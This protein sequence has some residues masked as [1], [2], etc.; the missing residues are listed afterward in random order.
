MFQSLD[1]R[2]KWVVVLF[3]LDILLSFVALASGAMEYQLLSAFASGDLSGYDNPIAAA[4]ASDARQQMIGIVQIGLYVSCIIAFLVWK[5]RAAANLRASGRG[6]LKFTPGWAVGWYFVPIASLVKP[7]QAMREIWQVS[8]NGP[9][10]NTPAVL[11]T[12]WTFWLLG[13]LSGQIAFRLSR[14]AETPDAMLRVSTASLASDALLIV[15]GALIIVIV[16][17]ISWAQSQ[18]QFRSGVQVTAPDAQWPPIAPAG[19]VSQK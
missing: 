17:R 12:W 1:T 19:V 4:E 6:P 14:S 11:G 16:R 5:H 10:A 7:L 9:V 13:N 18:P 3:S 2:C 8:H 15:S